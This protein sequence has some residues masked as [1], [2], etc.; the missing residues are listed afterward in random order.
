ML[1]LFCTCNTLLLKKSPL[2][3]ICSK[4]MFA[5]QALNFHFPSGKL[6]PQRTSEIT[7]FRVFSGDCFHKFCQAYYRKPPK[8]LE[9]NIRPICINRNRKCTFT[10]CVLVV[11]R[12]TK[13]QRYSLI[14]LYFFAS[15]N[16]FF[17][18]FPVP[19]SVT[20]LSINF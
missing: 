8:G 18:A 12:H 14:E 10:H 3:S 2:V 9:V 7:G 17:S 11:G 16:R 5:W 6:N 19:L 15:H 1:I 13:F 20:P 4:F